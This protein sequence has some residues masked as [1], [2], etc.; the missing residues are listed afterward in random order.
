MQECL[1]SAVCVAAGGEPLSSRRVLQL[2][3]VLRSYAGECFSAV[4]VAWNKEQ[5]TVAASAEADWRLA[6]SQQGADVL[7]A[8]RRALK[9]SHSRPNVSAAGKGKGSGV[10][11]CNSVVVSA[12][13][14]LLSSS[15]ARLA[16]LGN[17][18]MLEFYL[19]VSGSFKLLELEAR[20]LCLLFVYQH[21]KL[22]H[23]IVKLNIKM[24][25]KYITKLSPLLFA[26]NKSKLV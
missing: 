6:S 18:W 3:R 11:S 16:G 23:V 19:P 25:H 13:W 20:N 24:L 14:F 1:L 22:K 26:Q 7:P 9:T 5:W 8:C 17:V 12:L 15:T 10:T 2:H 21:L 4:C